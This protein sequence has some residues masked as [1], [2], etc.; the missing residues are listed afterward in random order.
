MSNKVIVFWFRRDLRIE[1]NAGL[2]QAL[3][4]GIPVLPV[5]I[6]DSTILERLE[7]PYDR[8]VDYIH[9][10]LSGLKKEL[11][12]YGSGL[13]TF[14]GK[15]ADAFR[16]LTRSYTIESV[17]TNRDYEP[18]ARNR[19]QEIKQLLQAQNIPFYDYKD[20]VIFEQDEIIKP[21]GLPYTV[22]T[23][24]SK[25]WIGSLK[26][27]HYREHPMSYGNLY[28][29]HSPRI[30]A[31]SSMGFQRT[32]IVFCKPV[33]QEDIVCGYGKYRDYPG[34][35]QT[36]KLGTALR[37]GTISIRKCVAFAV[38]HS[39]VWLSELVWREF[40][41]QI[42]Y[43][44]PGVVDRSFKSRYDLIEWRNDETEYMY[45]CSGKTGYAIVDAGMN[46]LNQT[47]YMHN[48]VRM[49]AASFLCKH[50]LIDWRWGEAYFAQKLNDYDLASNNGNWQWVAGCGC[51][52]VPYFRI[53]NP[54]LQTRRF[55]QDM[56]YIKKW[57]PQYEKCTPDFIISHTAARQRALEVYQRALR[58]TP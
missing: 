4:T 32:D 16:E 45:W 22:Y 31:L 11:Q 39:P 13:H 6:F 35:D 19:D 23:P 41:M 17:Y 54:Q 56:S 53:F 26:P 9:Q 3:D 29:M 2:S 52:A 25:K 46:Q 10:A 27:E 28:P 20:Q 21:D 51:D 24:Y 50:L 37:F 44:F 48:R 12:K 49:I 14:Y 34:L 38:Q 40:F 33:L 5:F 55:D 47:G 42:L 7:D 58:P 30:P 1:D 43:H 57:N 36:T 8:R 15:P 18:G